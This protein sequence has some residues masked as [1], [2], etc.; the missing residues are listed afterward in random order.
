[1]V[2]R[3]GLI[4]GL[5]WEATS[6]YY[7]YFNEFFEGPSPWSQ[8][9]VLI[10]STDMARIVELQRA[11]D[12]TTTG[13]IMVDAA[14]RLFSAG[15]SVLGIGAN[16]MHHY[17]EVVAQAVTCEVVDIRECVAEDVKSLGG[18]R[19]GILGTAYVTQQDFYAQGIEKWGVDVIRPDDAAVQE[20][21][22][23]IFD[24]LTQGIVLEQSRDRVLEMGASL[25]ARGADVVGLCCTEF[26][27]LVGEHDANYAVVDS[28]KAHVRALLRSLSRL[29]AEST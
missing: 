15:A 28:T 20:L 16:T 29:A 9:A 13:E 18:S 19:V 5:S 2:A 26:G 23:I 4:G 11:D 6:C 1:M 10:D 12:W 7:R 25:V 14:H 21:Q 3:I 27:L 17:Y 8:P 22:R 24:E